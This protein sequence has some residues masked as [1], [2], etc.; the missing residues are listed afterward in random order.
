MTDMDF[1]V[2]KPFH[3]LHH[4]QPSEPSEIPIRRSLWQRFI[5]FVRRVTH[6]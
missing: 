3:T 5:D 2:K 1:A 4:A 6:L